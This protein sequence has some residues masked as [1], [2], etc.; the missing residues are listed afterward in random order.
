M[1]THL[2]PPRLQREARTVEAMIRRYCRDHHHSPELCH[3]CTNLLTYARPMRLQCDWFDVETLLNSVKDV[4]AG[5]A[6][7]RGVNLSI[8]LPEPKF[9]INGDIRQLRQVL[10]N[11]GRNAVDACAKGG[12]VSID[13]ALQRR[14][15][16]LTVS[17]DGCGIAPEDISSIFDPFFTRKEGGTGL[18]LSLS[19]KIVGAH[20]GE[21]LVNS[22]LNAGTIIKV[23]LPQL[24]E[25]V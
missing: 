20:G 17:D 11:L 14:D 23:V 1:D 10:I 2:F 22:K 25:A 7:E 9:R 13:G 6:A 15:V 5:S 12:H 8:N 19:H 24:G 3:E 4:V 18:G 21:I 16:F